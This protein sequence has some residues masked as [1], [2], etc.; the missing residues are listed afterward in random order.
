[1]I[2]KDRSLEYIS[3]RLERWYN[4]EIDFKEKE[5]SQLQF[6]GTILKNKPLSQ[7]LDVI[8]LSAPIRFEIKVNPD[9]KNKVMLYSLKK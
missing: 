3:E 8:T 9:Q 1:M 2:F 7:V 5:I 4:V 6:T